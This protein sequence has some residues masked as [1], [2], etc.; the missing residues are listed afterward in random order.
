MLEEKCVKGGPPLQCM[1]A[2]MK[3]Q[4]KNRL[5]ENTSCLFAVEIGFS[6]VGFLW[7][8]CRPA[9]FAL[10]RASHSRCN[11]PSL[12]SEGVSRLKWKMGLEIDQDSRSSSSA[13]S[14]I[15][16]RQLPL[17]TLSQKFIFSLVTIWYCFTYSRGKK[18]KDPYNIR[19]ME[20]ESIWEGKTNI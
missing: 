11:S 13:I 4:C 19:T 2:W 3:N 7:K 5:R 14:N 1:L 6:W 12:A 18:D 17:C 8:S 10:Q 9:T 16:A 20:M 15:N